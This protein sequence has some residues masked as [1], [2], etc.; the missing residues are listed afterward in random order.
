VNRTQYRARGP[1]LG[2]L[3]CAFVIVPE[4]AARS[5]DTPS[6]APAPRLIRTPSAIP[7]S[8]VKKM[9]WRCVG[10][11]NMG[12][13]I[14]AIAVVES[15]PNTYFVATASGGLIKTSNNGTT[16]EMLFDKE[17]TVSIGDL[18]VA[19]SDPKIVWVGTGENNPRNS[20]SY[21]DG[22]YKSTDGGKTWTNMGLKKSFQI[23]KIVIHPKDP[24]IVYV[25]ALGRLYGPNE[26]RGL[27]KTTDGGKSWKKALYV[28]D[29]TGVIDFRMDPFDPETLLVG[30]WERKRDEFDGFF[31]NSMDLWPTQDQYGPA[32]GQGPGGGLFKTTDGGTTWEKLNDAKKKNGLPTV[33][34]GRIGL[35]YS[36]KTK[37][38]VYAIIDTE[39]IGMGPPPRTVYLGITA[40][41]QDKGGLKVTLV[42]P[43]GPAGKG[44]VKEE[45]FIVKM[46]AAKIEN[47]EDF[48]DFLSKKK[49]NDVIKLTVTRGK[50]EM[51]LEVKLE[52]R[53]TPA[54]KKDGK[55]PNPKTPPPILGV[56]IAPSEEGVE[57]E[58][59]SADGPAAK[60]GLL[61]GEVIT[62][63]N[64]KKIIDQATLR[65]ALAAF[66]AGD[67]V[68]VSVLKD[69]TARTV[70][71]TLAAGQARG[72][73]GGGAGRAS[74]QR[75]YIL[76]GQVGG[77]QANKQGEQGKEGFQTGGVYMSKD[78]GG[79]WT[80][81]NSINPR[82]FYFSQIR[83]DPN[84]DKLIYVAGD[85]AYFKSTDGGKKFDRI[86]TREVHPDIHALWIDPKDSRHMLLGCD[87]GF[88]LSYD[89]GTT[90]DHMNVL[91][92]GQFYHVAVDSRKLYRV[93][94]GL[95]DNGSWVGPSHV[96]RRVGPVNDDWG[97]ILGGDGFVC[98][99]DPNDSDLVYSESQN[100][101][102][103][104]HNLRTGER[105]GFGPVSKSGEDNRRNWNTPFILS[106][107]NPGIVYAASQYVSR[108][109]KQGTGLKIISPEITRTKKGSGTA[110]CESPRNSDVL[111]AG[112]DDGYLWVTRDGGQNWAN[113]YDKL[114]AAGLP[115]PYWVASIEA[116]RVKEGRCYV[117]L[118][119][120]RSND[121]RPH[122]YVT[123]DFGQSWSSISSNLPEFGSTRVLR[124]DITNPE[125]LYTGT[126]FGIHVTVN[127]GKS[128]TKLNSNLPTVA[129][130]EVAQPT[131]A[132]E[133]VVATHGRSIWI[134]DVA[135]LRQMAPH[136]EGDKTTDPLKESATLFAPPN[137]VRWMLRADLE[138]S[139]YSKNLRKFY[140]ANPDRRASI[141]YALTKPAKELSLKI[142]DA[143]GKIVTEFRSASK[144]VGFHRQPWSLNRT[145]GSGTAVP[146][147]TYRVVLTVDGK[148]YNQG[149]TVENDPHADPKAI[150]AVEAEARRDEE[151]REKEDWD[152]EED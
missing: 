26:E 124:E 105:G 101:N 136:T 78:N 45:D 39:R 145:G 94:G 112:S 82:P 107:H 40:E 91:A 42:A 47:Y 17:T 49:P 35:D 68:K 20:V 139:Q 100:G 141:D 129:V 83:V 7:D 80:R 38:L 41:N 84:D 1:F 114:K 23:G 54:P 33:K 50:K 10:P 151:E 51:V 95:Q 109:V 104:R 135:S 86:G 106:S 102:I 67:K 65:T 119:A 148:E 111:W 110:L 113:V 72:P 128:W 88:Y 93:F 118:D 63:V 150:V 79:S 21:G 122:L 30:L 142:L 134:L 53:E 125:V 121:D 14:T 69:K 89:R 19:P 132:S 37:G 18:A 24:N 70:E 74:I 116:S 62:A 64:G 71:V 59:L 5:A 12:G 115:G 87:G 123:E 55:E 22:V 3:A 81:V 76:G 85:T 56:Q 90:W 133:I 108:S 8:Y 152:D 120:H 13:R 34:T 36:R 103:N 149:I 77:Q 44:G 131:T 143:A 27:F 2:L 144:E 92:L 57:I 146:A 138:E 130:H 96:L 25:G 43:D 48:D 9:N 98:R 11:A 29:K 46:D 140:G 6:I 127:R 66:K 32:V 99:V 137:A 16:F 73:G 4:W 31:G 15:D 28:D 117:A 75:P 58:D 52:P 147:G 126:E 60:A 61:K 97:T